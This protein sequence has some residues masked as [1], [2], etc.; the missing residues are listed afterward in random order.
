MTSTSRVKV[1][2]TYVEWY[3]LPMLLAGI[4]ILLILLPN[5]A[6]GVYNDGVNT[7]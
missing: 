1:A 5:G 6:S 7:G 4:P 3:I 2:I